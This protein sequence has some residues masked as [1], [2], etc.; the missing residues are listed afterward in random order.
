MMR[1]VVEFGEDEFH[2]LWVD[3]SCKVM[4]LCLCM[5]YFRVEDREYSQPDKG[6]F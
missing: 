3:Y 2:E 4:N 1:N 5:N 6:A